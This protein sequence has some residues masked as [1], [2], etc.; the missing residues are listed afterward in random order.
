[1][2]TSVTTSWLKRAQERETR[3]LL[4]AD[5]KQRLP[6]KG[7]WEINMW[8]PRLVGGAQ[9]LWCWEE[10]KPRGLQGQCFENQSRHLFQFPGQEAG[11]WVIGPVYR[12]LSKWWIKKVQKGGIKEETAIMESKREIRQ[13][14]KFSENRNSGSSCYGIVINSAQRHIPHPGALETNRLNTHQ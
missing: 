14:N 6:S 1:M 10:Q 4:S 9:C 3:S 12:V 13:M 2:S 8:I 5:T 7:F 11:Y